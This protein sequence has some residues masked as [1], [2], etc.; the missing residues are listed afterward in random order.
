MYWEQLDDHSAR[1][2][3]SKSFQECGGLWRDLWREEEL[4]TPK[5]AP[6]PRGL[7]LV[8]D[9]FPVLASWARSHPETAFGTMTDAGTSL[10]PTHG[11]RTRRH[12]PTTSPRPARKT[13]PPCPLESARICPSQAPTAGQLLLSS[14]ALSA[15]FVELPVLFLRTRVFGRQTRTAHIFPHGGFSPEYHRVLET[16]TGFGGFALLLPLPCT[17][18]IA[19][20]QTDQRDAFACH[21]CARS[22]LPRLCLFE[23]PSFPPPQP[24]QSKHASDFFSLAAVYFAVV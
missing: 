20:D 11:H 23:M 18:I 6:G 4:K 24:C 12:Q 9:M 17:C 8:S 1:R 15:A 10:R 16:W 13:R 5:K 14:P 7:S 3:Q 2:K 21:A 19:R 22:S